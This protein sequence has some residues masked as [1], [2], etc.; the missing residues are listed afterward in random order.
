ARV[1]DAVM[2]GRVPNGAGMTSVAGRCGAAEGRGYWFAPTRVCFRRDADGRFTAPYPFYP[3]DG[4][5]PGG[6]A[7]PRFRLDLSEG[8]QGGVAKAFFATVEVTSAAASHAYPAVS[9]QN[10]GR[11]CGRASDFSRQHG[12]RLSW[13]RA[14]FLWLF[15][16]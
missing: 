9:R 5:G 12:D 2:R 6:L 14:R 1:G 13:L 11:F 16:I 7:F 10:Y 8:G 15:G 4:R 3:N